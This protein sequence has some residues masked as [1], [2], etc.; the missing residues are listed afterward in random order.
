[1]SCLLPYSSKPNLPPFSLSFYSAYL[2]TTRNF[3]AFQ[4]MACV[5]SHL[6]V[7]GGT[8]GFVYNTE[9]HRLDLNSLVW[10]KLKPKNIASEIPPER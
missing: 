8:S 10:E 5:Q 6:Y 3:S 1:M 2:F 9:L 7:Y 4:A